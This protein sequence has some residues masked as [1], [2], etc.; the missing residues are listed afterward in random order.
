MRVAIVDSGGI[1]VMN[2]RGFTV[3]QVINL[4]EETFSSIGGEVGNVTIVRGTVIEWARG[5][6]AVDTIYG[7]A[8]DNS[9]WG[10]DGADVMYGDLGIDTAYGGFGD[11]IIEG[12][13]GNDLNGIN[14]SEIWTFRRDWYVRD[15]KGEGPTAAME[16]YGV[17][18][19]VGGFENWERGD[20][21]QLWRKNGSGHTAVFWDW[22]L[23]DDD[24][25]MGLEY[26]S[27][28]GD[29]LDFN[30]EYF[31]SHG[32]ALDPQYMWAARGWLPEYWY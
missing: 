27:C 25:I 20:F 7:N 2:Y 26:V 9:F 8:A 23:D 29:G 15:L 19:D 12:G 28:Q 16:N 4:N 21:V 31:G 6:S 30:D 18:T 10:Y 22:I 1:D 3:D 24:S 5:G 11:D 32:S 14:D 17:G 13:D